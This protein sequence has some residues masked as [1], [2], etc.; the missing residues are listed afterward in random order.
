MKKLAD[1]ETRESRKSFLRQYRRSGRL[2]GSE[3]RR[4]KVCAVC[5]APYGKYEVTLYAET[6]IDPEFHALEM[7]KIYLCNLCYL[8]LSQVEKEELNAH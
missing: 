8:T 2:L 7:G 1:Y 5:D 4:G 6:E 3:E